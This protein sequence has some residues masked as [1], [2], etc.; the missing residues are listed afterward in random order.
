MNLT[1]T[2]NKKSL[3]LN[4]SLSPRSGGGR[5]RDV[6][7]NN[8]SVV[9]ENGVAVIP[10]Y[11]TIPVTDVKYNGESVVNEHGV[12]IIPIAQYAQMLTPAQYNNLTPAEK[13]NGKI[14][15]I[16]ESVN[17]NVDLSG[18]LEF[19]ESGIYITEKTSSSVTVYWNGTPYIGHY[20]YIPTPIDVTNFD[21]IKYNLN[22]GACYGG[23]PQERWK[24]SI[25]LLANA[26]TG[27]PP[28][29]Y[30]SWSWLVNNVYDTPN[31]NYTN[32]SLDV[33]SLTGNVYLAVYDV[34]WG[35]TVSNV[36]AHGVNKDIKYMDI[37]F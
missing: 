18:A 24:Y 20:W 12:A 22:L 11:P 34:G 25:G 2:I 10:P 8:E 17:N 32:Q 1:G 30:D 16:Y 35:E 33:S 5:V 31:T 21:E 4:A 7:Y 26:P 27:N 6:V 28:Q 36:V 9:N 14:Y 37:S 29:R 3:G 15:F 19:I 23:T 13:V